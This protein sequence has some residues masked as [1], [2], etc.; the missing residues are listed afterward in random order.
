MVVKK[1]I[2]FVVGALLSGAIWIATTIAIGLRPNAYSL[3]ASAFFGGSLGASLTIK[4]TDYLKSAENP[5]P[6]KWWGANVH[7]RFSIVL[8]ALWVCGANI[9]IDTYDRNFTNTYAP[10]IFILF[11]YAAFSLLVSPPEK[12][13]IE[14]VPGLSPSPSPHRFATAST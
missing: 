12:A 6:K 9:F 10:A 11:S 2:G 3:L 5:I 4:F 1:I 13:S 8:S 14:P 7:L